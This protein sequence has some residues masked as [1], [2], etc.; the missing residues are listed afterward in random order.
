MSES[1]QQYDAALKWLLARASELLG[2]DAYP[3]QLAWDV[4]RLV[5]RQTRRVKRHGLSSA[6]PLLMLSD[7]SRGHSLMIGLEVQRLPTASG[8]VRLVFVSTPYH[9]SVDDFYAIATRD[10][11]RFY[12][13]VRQLG[14]RVGKQTP[15]LL[16]PE[17]HRSLWDNTIGWFTRDR[18][19]MAQFDLPQRR[20]A[21][22]L[23]T[24]GNGK[25]MACRWLRS[26]CLRRGLEWSSVSRQ[27]FE[28]AASDGSTR[29]L[30]ELERPGVVLFDDFE[31]A[32]RDRAKFGDQ[33][34]STFLTELDGMYPKSGVVYLFT[35]NLEVQDI[36]RAALRPGRVDVVLHFAP[37]TAE[38]RRRLIV[39]RWQPE[40]VRHLPLDL[41]VEETAGQSFAELEETRKLL[42]L[43][44]LDHD[45]VD[46]SV[47][48]KHLETNRD[49]MTHR[50]VLGFGAAKS[51]VL[52][53]DSV[54]ALKGTANNK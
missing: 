1:L 7:G 45:V 12:R 20:G 9:S 27:Q 15:P 24:P 49:G 22:L 21:L 14:R 25:T 2:S 32:L 54:C 35:S 40:I 31:A 43:H 29:E 36:D 44:Y 23:G 38:L 34:Q 19:R 41:V 37:P 16:S 28:S 47:T 18:D 10:V 13:H 30:F 6:P 3:L 52:I 39:E 46:W 51:S 17:I 42:V 26:E 4:E 50:K 53:E 48:R 8:D 33:H 5:R 11:P